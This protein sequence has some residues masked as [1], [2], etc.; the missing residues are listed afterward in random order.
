MIYKRHRGEERF[1][2]ASNWRHLIADHVNCVPGGIAVDGVVRGSPGSA[3]IGPVGGDE[4]ILDRLQSTTLCSLSFDLF[5]SA[6][7]CA[8]QNE[9]ARTSKECFARW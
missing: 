1:I 4:L 3:A 7:D 5:E 9:V 8:I 2:N 6:G